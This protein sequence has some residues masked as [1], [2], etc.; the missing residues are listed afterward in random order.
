MSHEHAR[1]ILYD[2]RVT[3]RKYV[4][5]SRPRMRFLLSSPTG[6]NRSSSAMQPRVVASS[7]FSFG[8]RYPTLA[9]CSLTFSW[10]RFR[11]KCARMCRNNVS[12]FVSRFQGTIVSIRLTPST[13]RLF[14]PTRC[15]FR[16]TEQTLDTYNNRSSVG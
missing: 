8:R 11:N 2:N 13:D 9:S 1:T 14:P 3:R 10:L 12:N 16:S 15:T 7:A 6:S 5:P 4:T